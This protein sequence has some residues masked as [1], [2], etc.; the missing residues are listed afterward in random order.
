MN[1]E[2]SGALPRSMR[3]AIDNAIAAEGQHAAVD[4]RF[5]EQ[6]SLPRRSARGVVALVGVLAAA[7][8]IWAYQARSPETPVA[9]S[10]STDPA[11]APPISTANDTESTEPSAADL[12]LAASS[13]LTIGPAAS[14]ASGE[15]SLADQP[16]L[17]AV[18]EDE[19]LVGYA[20]SEDVFFELVDPNV[21]WSGFYVYEADGT[22]I[23]GVTIFGEGYTP[24]DE[25]P[26]PPTSAPSPQPDAV[27][28]N[29]PG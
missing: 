13:G 25:N 28:G 3:A 15:A 19:G 5:L 18:V 6:R 26:A 20:R 8:G 21:D 7:S 10:T 17:I 16:D 1:D 4:M 22:T 24:I 2:Q 27:P 14:T 29:E 11:P 12:Q 9:V 23:V